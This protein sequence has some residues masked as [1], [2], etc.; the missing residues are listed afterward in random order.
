MPMQ[1]GYGYSGSGPKKNSKLKLVAAGAVGLAVGGALGVGSYYA[2]KQM[3]EGMSGTATD[4]SWCQAPGATGR[5]MS[6]RECFSA[7]GSRCTP[8]NK[9]YQPG[10]CEF[11]MGKNME[12]DDIMRAGFVPHLYTPPLTITITKLSGGDI[13]KNTICT[14]TSVDVDLFMTLTQVENFETSNNPNNPNN[15]NKPNN[16]N[17]QTG[18]GTANIA[19]L[20]SPALPLLLLGLMAFIRMAH[21]RF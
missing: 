2:Y 13:T 18:V 4:Q 7:H 17:N 1:T 10:G 14:A 19:R 16:P 5:M 20:Q 9:C 6:C 8:E 12:R 21:H 11:E 3:S 15:P